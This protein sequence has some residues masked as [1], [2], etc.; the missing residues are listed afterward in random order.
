MTHGYLRADG[1]KGI[2]NVLVVAYTVECSQHVAY[3]IA[4]RFRDRGVHL[5]GFPGCYPNPYAQRM[6]ERLCT[7]PNV[8]GVLAVSL[9]CES[10]D[11]T[12]L[13]DAIRESGRPVCTVVIQELGGTRKTIEAGAA[14]VSEALDRIQSVPRIEM[15][16]EELVVG[17]ICGASDATSGLTAN[18]AIG[19]A[20]DG[21]VER[22]ATVIFEE[23]GELIGCEQVSHGEGSVDIG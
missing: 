9:G 3:E 15:S 11:R 10:L 1:R 22:G 13:A 4:G 21:L 5:I 12:R 6:M 23:T 20:S 7:H 14:W 8:G 17:A 19:R 16:V 2:R 18:P